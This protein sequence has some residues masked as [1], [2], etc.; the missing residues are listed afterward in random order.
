[1]FGLES[2]L[3]IKQGAAAL[4]QSTNKIFLDNSLV[5]SIDKIKTKDGIEIKPKKSE[6]A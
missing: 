6:L 5:Y 4:D 2:P 3:Q 1:M